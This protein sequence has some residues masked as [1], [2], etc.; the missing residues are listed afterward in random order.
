MYVSEEEHQS[1]KICVPY[2]VLHL[3]TLPNNANQIKELSGK[4]HIST[5]YTLTTTH[6][7]C[8]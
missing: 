6:T 1:L 4:S 7:M 5:T 2:N 8:L 3:F